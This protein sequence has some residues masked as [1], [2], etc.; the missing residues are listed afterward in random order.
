MIKYSLWKL[1]ERRWKKG[2]SKICFAAEHRN[3]QLSRDP[4]LPSPVIIIYAT[5]LFCNILMLH[6]RHQESM[7]T[8]FD[9]KQEKVIN[10]ALLL[11]R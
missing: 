6:Q 7:P 1:G 2:E 11:F 10:I 5:T 9:E 3:H 4:L 8:F